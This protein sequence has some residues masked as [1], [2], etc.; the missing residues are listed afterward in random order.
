MYLLWC[1]S[2]EIQIFG[3]DPFMP[4]M[5]NQSRIELNTDGMVILLFEQTLD[6][7][8]T[9]FLLSGRTIC[10]ERKWIIL[11]HKGKVDDP[12]IFNYW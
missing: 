9:V 10:G 7:M 2:E 8:G 3:G 4:S 12:E 6:K 1:L 5:Q 11:F